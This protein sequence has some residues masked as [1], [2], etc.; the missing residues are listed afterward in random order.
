M[1]VVGAASNYN[2]TLNVY[3]YKDHHHH[4]YQNYEL[5]GTQYQT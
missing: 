2:Q 5:K 4:E 3:E 1:V